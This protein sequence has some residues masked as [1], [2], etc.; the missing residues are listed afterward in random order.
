M[1]VVV[2]RESFGAA[3]PELFPLMRRNWEKLEFDKTVG[4]MEPSYMGYL[5]CED[6]GVLKLF[7]ARD[8]PAVV[9]YWLAFVLPSLQAGYRLRM[10]MD[11]FAVKDGYE[12]KVPLPLMR[13][14]EKFNKENGIDDSYAASRLRG[15]WAGRLFEAFGYEPFEVVYG[16][17]YTEPQRA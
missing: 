5:E 6:K 17:K 11:T 13:A 4:P 3:L 7:V 1:T 12:S 16:K 2:T 14:V 9:G 8:G 10:L 15:A